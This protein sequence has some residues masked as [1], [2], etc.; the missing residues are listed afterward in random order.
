MVVLLLYIF[1]YLSFGVVHSMKKRCK[2]CDEKAGDVIQ[3][4]ILYCASC[5]L[6]KFGNNVRQV[7]NYQPSKYRRPINFYD[8]DSNK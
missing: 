7:L 3:N 5:W 4:D 2:I 1:Y 6:K 8:I